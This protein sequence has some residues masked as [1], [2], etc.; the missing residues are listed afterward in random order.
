M[1][2]Q[3]GGLGRLL[4]APDRHPVDPAVHH[5]AVDVGPRTA[6]HRDRIAARRRLELLDVEAAG[7]QRA[8]AAIVELEQLQLLGGAV[9]VA[10]LPVAT[11]LAIL[12]LARGGL[13]IAGEHDA[14]AVGQPRER[15]HAGGQI[16]ESLGLAAVGGDPP[17]LV[18]ADHPRDD[19]RRRSSGRRAPTRARPR[20]RARG[21]TA[22]PRRPRCR[23]RTAR[24]ACR[25]ACRRCC[26]GSGAR[27][28]CDARR[29][30]PRR[31]RPPADRRCPR[32]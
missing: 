15:A 10:D 27:R 8:H 20:C 17:Q 6:D 5:R 25:P 32:R 23:P 4:G 14:L 21:C 24:D 2:A 3:P 12:L 22:W 9:D 16:G 7:R 29:G 18:R 26:A 13:A 1:V 11:G 28:R 30:S 31:R 19:R